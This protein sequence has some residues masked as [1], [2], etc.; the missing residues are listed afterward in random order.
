MDENNVSDRLSMVSLLMAAVVAVSGCGGSDDDAV[1][2]AAGGSAP[3][4]A[5]VPSPSPSPSP[6]PAPAN[7]SASL[8]WQAA[9]DADVAGYRVYYGTA[10]GSYTQPRGTGLN[11]GNVVSFTVSGLTRG[12]AYFFA[13]SAYDGAGNESALS[14]EVSKMLP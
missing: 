5:P 14:G 9:P 1:D 3:A 7:G 13:V 11:A 8:N 10:S 12:R 4:P 6:S 2:P